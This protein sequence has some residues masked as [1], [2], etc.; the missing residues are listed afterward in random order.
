MTDGILLLD[1][2]SGPTSHRVLGCVRRWAGTRRAGHTGT[3]DPLATGLLPVLIGRATMLAPFLPAE[4]K[5]YQ[6]VARFGVRTDTGDA[7]GRVVASTDAGHTAPVEWPALQRAHTGALK[8]PIPLYAA[9]K[10]QGRPLYQY[11]RRNQPVEVPQKTMH[12]LSLRCDVSGWPWVRLELV[13]GAGTYVRAVAEAL[14]RAT[15]LGAHV[16]S[17]RRTAIADWSVTE[18]V[19]PEQLEPGMR[20]E[21]AFI[22]IDAALSLPVL[23]L[24]EDDARRVGVGR[25]PQR[26]RTTNQTFLRSGERFTFADSAGHLLAVARTRTAWGNSVQ[27]PCFDWER[28]LVASGCR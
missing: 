21:R 16:L 24:D 2:P 17:L 10:V 26:V 18:A 23:E 27:P 6:A 8:L 25:E 9:V 14:G 12:V 22:P 7:D 11:A 28:V 19:K 15:G 20:P 4:P 3:L 1:K 13:C 5:H